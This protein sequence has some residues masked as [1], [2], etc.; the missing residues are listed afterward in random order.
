MLEMFVLNVEI[1]ILSGV[2][3]FRL[4]KVFPSDC[5]VGEK[6][7]GG[8]GCREDLGFRRGKG[9]VLSPPQL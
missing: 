7:M 1:R 5:L 4:G 9:F 8:G 3:I 6:G 2:G